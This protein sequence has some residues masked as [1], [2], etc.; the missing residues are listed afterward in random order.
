MRKNFAVGGKVGNIFLL[1]AADEIH[2][3]IHCR[4]GNKPTTENQ[5]FFGIKIQRTSPLYR[6]LKKKK[7]SWGRQKGN[8]CLFHPPDYE[9]NTADHH[10]TYEI[11]ILYQGQHVNGG[12]DIIEPAEIQVSYGG[13]NV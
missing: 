1:V 7:K 9:N 11:G 4:N 2:V 6:Q 5:Q 13:Y 8:K 3:D 12:K 10:K